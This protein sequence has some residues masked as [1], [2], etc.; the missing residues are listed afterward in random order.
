[1][2]FDRQSINSLMCSHHHCRGQQL[3]SVLSEPVPSFSCTAF[4]AWFVTGCFLS[5]HAAMYLYAFAIPGSTSASFLVGFGLR[6]Q[7]SFMKTYEESGL[8]F[9]LAVGTRPS[10]SLVTNLSEIKLCFVYYKAKTPQPG[11]RAIFTTYV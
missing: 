2:Y 4:S 8:S 9:L 5:L 7:V 11:I 10:S 1:M 6:S 3:V